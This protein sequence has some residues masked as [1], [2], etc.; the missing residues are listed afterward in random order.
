MTSTQYMQVGRRFC[1][2][3]ATNYTL[4]EVAVEIGVS[5]Q[6]VE[7][8]S[9]LAMGKLIVGLRTNLAA[10]IQRDKLRAKRA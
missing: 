4:D 1:K 8:I 5:R 7:Q 6:R 2:M 10:D 9:H 3:L